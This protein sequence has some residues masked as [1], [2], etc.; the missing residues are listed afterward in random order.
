MTRNLKYRIRMELHE[1]IKMRRKEIG[2]TQKDL[3][4]KIG[5]TNQSI[6]NF[7]QSGT[8]SLSTFK[9]MCDELDLVIDV[10]PKEYRKEPSETLTYDVNKCVNLLKK[11]RE[12]LDNLIK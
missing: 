7:E 9:R 12:T 3:A 2:V 8:C 11:V 6:S 10:Y 1:T 5:V 4:K